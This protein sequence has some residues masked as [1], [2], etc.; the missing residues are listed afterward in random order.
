MWIKYVEDI[1]KQYAH[2]KKKKSKY[3]K[4]VGAKKEEKLEEWKINTDK[5]R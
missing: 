1:Y 2:C 4:N 5:G 3:A